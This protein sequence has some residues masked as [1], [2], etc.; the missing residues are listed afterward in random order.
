MSINYASVANTY[1]IE[2]GLPKEDLTKSIRS[3]RALLVSFECRLD[4][5]ATC[6]V[7]LGSLALVQ[8]FVL[9]SVECIYAKEQL[10]G[11]LFRVLYTN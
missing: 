8:F 10:S 7:R 2:F 11:P 3:S 1:T 6:T 5:L 4:Q 9:A